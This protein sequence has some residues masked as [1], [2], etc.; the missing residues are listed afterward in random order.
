MEDSDTGLSRGGNVIG[1]HVVYKVKT[2]ENSG[3]RLKAT[4]CRMAIGT[5]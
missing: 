2:E 1:S 4:I 3:R 5:I